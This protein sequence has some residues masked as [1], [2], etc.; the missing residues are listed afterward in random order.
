MLM[1]L[2]M[3][4]SESAFAKLVDYYKDKTYAPRLLDSPEASSDFLQHIDKVL[5]DCDGV[6][7]VPQMRH[8]APRLA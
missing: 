1:S 8:P 7:T 2:E 6:C 4:L 5:F 3:M